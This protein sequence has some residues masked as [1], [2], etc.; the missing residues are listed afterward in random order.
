MRTTT[1]LECPKEHKAE[2]IPT[3]AVIT[4]CI[5]SILQI[6][7]R[8]CYYHCPARDNCR[9][10]SSHCG[11]SLKKSIANYFHGHD[12][13]VTIDEDRHWW[14]T[15]CS[16]SQSKGY[17]TLVLNMMIYQYQALFIYSYGSKYT[18]IRWVKKQKNNNKK[19]QLEIT[20]PLFGELSLFL[21][22]GMLSVFS[23]TQSHSTT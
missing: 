17:D 14:G 11:A 1:Q 16:F 13:K 7:K 2:K 22:F 12:E 9:A 15:R 5:A 19:K 4:S 20:W 10:Q 8:C 23:I 21:C 3:L 18:D 6:Q